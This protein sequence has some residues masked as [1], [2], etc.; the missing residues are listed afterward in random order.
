M[1]NKRIA[2][3]GC[4]RIAQRHIEAIVANKGL[5]LAILNDYMFI[6]QSLGF[7]LMFIASL[8]LVRKTVQENKGNYD[9]FLLVTAIKMSFMML[10]I[11]FSLGTFGLWIY[12]SFRIRKNKATGVLM[13]IAAVLMLVM[14]GLG[15]VSFS[16]PTLEWIPES[17]NVLW[18][19]CFGL[20]GILFC[21]NC[22]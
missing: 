22:E 18:Q 17:I 9:P 8:L 10:M 7:V 11:V 6:L 4:G 12:Y 13:I 1:K 21:R 19:S 5:E 16:N 2:V 15:S 3:V 14:G 20:A